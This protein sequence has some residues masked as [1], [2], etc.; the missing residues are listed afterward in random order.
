M[1]L[2]VHPA[3]QIFGTLFAL[4]ALRFGWLRF[5]AAHLGRKGLFPWK[6]HVQWG[7]LAQLVWIGGLA[8]GVWAARWVWRG[9][10]VT[11]AHF[12]IGLLMAALIAFSFVSG[13]IMDRVK[14]KRTLLPLLHAL[15]GFALLALALAELATG[16]F[17]LAR[18]GL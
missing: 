14:K 9:S 8:L 15:A 7:Q 18:V 13:T 17:V 5:R 10:G 6:E 12:P 2:W 4:V 11:G 1:M 3:T 16:A